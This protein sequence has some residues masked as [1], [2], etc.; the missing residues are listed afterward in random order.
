MASR[1]RVNLTSAAVRG[2]PLEKTT[3]SRM[4]I[5]QVVSST[6]SYSVTIIGTRDMSL[7]RR[8]RR[9]PIIWN[10]LSVLLWAWA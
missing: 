6:I 7:A 2:S 5:F 9:T 1:S 8:N 3:S 4:V 10:M